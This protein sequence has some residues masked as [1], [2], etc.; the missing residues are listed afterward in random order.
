MSS[1]TWKPI[2]FGLTLATT[3]AACGGGGG[4]SDAPTPTPTPS[5]TPDAGPSPSPTPD[6]GSTP[7]PT[8]TPTSYS[9]TAK[10]GGANPDDSSVSYT[11]QTAR[12]LLIAD[13]SS[14]SK[15]LEEGDASNADGYR[16]DLRFYL[17]GETIDTAAPL[18]ALEGQALFDSDTYGAISTGK[19]LAG[20]I[21]GGDGQGGGETSKLIDDEF[22]GWSD[23]LEDG[24]T[25]INLVNL[26]IDRIVEQAT[27]GNTPTV[28]T[29]D[30]EFAL[31][32]YHDNFGRDYQQLIQKFLLGAVTFS[33]GTNDYLKA[34]GEFDD[35]LLEREDDKP[36]SV[37]EHEWDEAFGYFG[38][39]R[40]YADYSDDEIAAKGG[41]ADYENGYHDTNGDSQIDPRS[42]YN[43]GN[44]TNCAKRDRGSNG[45]TDFTKEAF[46]AFL[47]GRQL[48]SD[49]TN[50][51]EFSEDVKAQLT[52]YISTA[53]VT[54]EKCVA[55]TV[56]HYIND[57]ITD[58]RATNDGQY[59]ANGDGSFTN[60]AKHWSEMKG[61]ALGL[62]F[63]PYSPFRTEAND[64]TVDDLKVALE[65]MGDAPVLADGT[66]LGE[67]FDGGIEQYIENLL[68][69]RNTF[70]KAYDFDGEVV[71]N[72]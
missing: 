39:A 47:A 4:G 11:G 6:T 32:T 49:A 72:W 5:P 25:P 19:N 69:V 57:T 70:Q 3:L 45:I 17:N 18:F 24:A 62:Q 40:D 53:A 36:Y 7:T 43:F 55:A 8:E 42:E 38:A 51:G 61:F 66:H 50:T 56:V 29:S 16:A 13:M 15:S 22:F 35:G 44:S 37:G 64:V 10:V 48:V 30:G 26:Y 63:S 21:A 14:T 58:L 28:S 52:E 20:K 31:Q 34:V 2:L 23:S 54:W 65:L 1:L 12:H 9:F 71:E 67:A 27:D 33:Q 46:D 68:E 41:R 60:L 59:A